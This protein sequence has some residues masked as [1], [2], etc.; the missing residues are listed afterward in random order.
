[1]TTLMA[2]DEEFA[3]G[4]I[5]VFI[6]QQPQLSNDELILRFVSAV[7]NRAD[8]DFQQRARRRLAE[9][10]SVLRLAEEDEREG[11]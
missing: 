10:C 7:H 1:M 11:E 6:G 9:L 2:D 5:A 3:K 4:L 8:M